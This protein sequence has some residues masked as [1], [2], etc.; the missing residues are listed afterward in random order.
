MSIQVQARL[1][2]DFGV[3]LGVG[4]L[5]SHTLDTLA[6][7]LVDRLIDLRAVSDR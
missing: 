6:E 2:A 7:E 3:R 5:L 1:E 4:T